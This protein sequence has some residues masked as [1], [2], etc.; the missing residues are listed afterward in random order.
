ML[1]GDQMK[2]QEMTT[3]IK[4]SDG[5]TLVVDGKSYQKY[6]DWYLPRWATG[7]LYS[8]HTKKTHNEVWLGDVTFKR[9]VLGV[10]KSLQ[11]YAG[12]RFGYVTFN[13][14][15]AIPIL[16]LNGEVWMSLTPME[17]ISQRAGLRQAKGDVLIGGLG[18]GWLAIEVAKK[19]SVTS[20]TVIEHNQRV[21]ELFKDKVCEN[22]KVM[23]LEDDAYEYAYKMHHKFDSILFDVWESYGRAYNDH[24]FWKIND[25]SKCTVWG[26]GDIKHL[27][28]KLMSG[29]M[30]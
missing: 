14:P 2:A 7:I 25:V 21:I 28:A 12:S 26:W 9:S 10:G 15:I 13:S 19:K 6:S 5:Q 8:D 1:K 24:K 23:V 16:M 30:S 18:M 4:F 11:V 29:W 20:V 27:P 22:P 17:I 3:G